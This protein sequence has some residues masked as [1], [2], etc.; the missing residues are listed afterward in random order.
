MQKKSGSVK[1]FSANESYAYK[2][3]L[4]RDNQVGNNK[5]LQNVR[6]IEEENE[7]Y[8][9]CRTFMIINTEWLGFKVDLFLY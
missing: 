2:S 8:K 6:E 1:H 7:Y 3:C 9:P 5:A 4:N